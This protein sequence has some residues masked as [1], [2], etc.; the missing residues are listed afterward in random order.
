MQYVELNHFGKVFDRGMRVRG[1]ISKDV[2][3]PFP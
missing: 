3:F 1:M 2:F